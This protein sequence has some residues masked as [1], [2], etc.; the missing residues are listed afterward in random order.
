MG[1]HLNYKTKSECRM[2]FVPEEMMLKKRNEELEKAIKESKQR[3]EK[4]KTKL[5]RA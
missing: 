3:E 4:I 2:D 1:S 5:Q